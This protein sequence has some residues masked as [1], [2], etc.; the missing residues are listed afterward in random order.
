M[1]TRLVSHFAR[2]LVLAMGLL[3]AIGLGGNFSSMA[4]R[5]SFDRYSLE[6][7]LPQ[8]QV[9]DV[10]QGDRGYLW[11]A[12]LGGGLT[13]FDGYSFK[14]FTAE[15]GLPS[16][17]A[18][19][20]H[21]DSSGTL[22]VGTRNGLARY[23]GGTI[24]SFT[25]TDGLADDHVQ[26]LAEGPHGTLW[27][28][29]PSGVFS[30]REGTFRALAPDQ[31]PDVPYR[32]LA[33]QG[34]T[35]WIGGR[36]G[37]HRYDDTGLTSFVDT[38]RGPTT[39]ARSLVPRTE[40]GLWV[41]TRNG[42]FRFADAEFRRV[43][44]TRSLTVLDVLDPPGGPLWLAT[45][46]GLYRRPADDQPPRRFSEQLKNV[47]V[48][49]LLRDS[50]HSL[51][52]ATDGEGLLQHSPTPFDH[53]TTTDGLAHNLVWDVTAGP[54]EDL[55]I[56]TRDGISRYD[57]TTFTEVT[58]P[59]G[60]LDREL[61]SLHYDHTGTLWIATRTG[62]FSYD[63][64]TYTEHSQVGGGRVGLTVDIAETPSGTLWFATLQN[65]LIRYDGSSFTRYTTED[66][67]SSNHVRALS[68]GP[69]GRL[70]VG[71]QEGLQRFD[72]DTFT[73]LHAVDASQV[74]SL[75][76]L[77]VDPDGYAWLGTQRGVHLYRPGADSLVPFT[78]NDGLSGSTTV[79]LLL[80][81]Q[82]HLWAGTEK[83]VNR[84]DIRGYKRT[85]TMALRSYGPEDGFLGT[86][87]SQHA[88]YAAD[89]GTLW[90]GTGDG[91]TR[92][93]P[94]A[95]R[96]D[97]TPPQVYVTGLRFF[98]QSPADWAQ[99]SDQQAPWSRL[100]VGLRLPHDKNH[101]IF[102]FTG[103]N[104]RAP[105]EVNYQYKLE[106]FDTQWS[107]VQTQRRATYSNIPPGS[108]TFKVKARDGSGPW[109][110]EAATFS[111]SIEPP[112]WQT[113]WFYV[114]CVL[115]AIGLVVGVIRWRTWS[116]EQRQRLLEDK[117]AERTK[118]LEAARE[119]AL[120]AAEAKSEFLANMSHEIR[121]PMNG[122]IG[123][124][125][126]LE[127]TPLSPEQQEFVDAIQRSGDTLL[128]IIDDILD[129]SKLEAG[130]TDLETQ[131]VRLRS[132]VEE[133][134]DPLAT[135]TAEKGV[136]LTYRIDPD[137]PSVIRTDKTRLHQV[138]LNLLSN[139]VKFTEEGTVALH[140]DVVSAPA[141]PNQPYELHFQVRDTGP[142]IPEEQQDGLF[143]SFR[144]A[145]S[146]TT[147]TH[148]GTGLGLSIA[149]QIV[150]AMEGE[151]WVE[152]EV[153]EGSTFHFTIRAAAEDLEE[154][155]DVPSGL[156]GRRVL[157]AAANPTTRALL[158]Q[159][160]EQGGME[161]LPAATDSALLDRLR[162][163]PAFDLI[164]LDARLADADGPAL[165]THL[166]K[167]DAA[168]APIVLLS[169]VQ[170][171]SK[172]GDAAYDAQVHKPI[173]QS[174]L[175]AAM[176]KALGPS[177]ASPQIADGAPARPDR[178]VLRVLLAEDDTVNQQMT[179][180]LLNERG[181]EVQVATTG[182][183]AVEAFREQSPDVIL[184]DVQMPE[185]DGL[186][187]TRRIRDEWPSDEQPYIIA[188]TAAVTEADR[189]R[190]QE[191]GADD[192]LSKPLKSEALADALPDQFGAA[193]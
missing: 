19:A 85:G 98:S 123:F 116:L 52:L 102:R 28:G 51:W 80:D 74:G 177:P 64:G 88:V 9:R 127:D 151:I 38:T 189:R 164:L 5:H 165:A 143:D 99:Y 26:A 44:D 141:E 168:P 156:D 25:Q 2:G 149:K 136:E 34:D 67:L 169:S 39:P 61:P 49:G 65:G 101:L 32:S 82:G 150:E 186:E 62:L 40:G 16:N 147:R 106:G 142:G 138:L 4:Q 31:I 83:G 114:L 87:A 140:V 193:A 132:S 95:D 35:L 60:A 50:D 119:D 171:D 59:N 33:T 134:L 72:G 86:E 182:S 54:D 89:N 77:T 79:S 90:F 173:K 146:S 161:A 180:Q 43:G 63:D 41:G 175:Y 37:V 66:G 187:A 183:E 167:Q 170:Q 160:V 125:D 29:T 14:S 100:P 70:W 73:A 130:Q 24:T 157:V 135:A 71:L 131:P 7:G 18:T 120:A 145:D 104:Y 181:H 133:A 96:P 105:T 188:L 118:E 46:D 121:T 117:V 22:W 1:R 13:R 124:A 158:R 122:V 190:C 53:F 11:L 185:M 17:V 191:A 10:L 47:V 112:F 27:I 97:P 192:F 84:L 111:F 174:H 56:A 30:F 69:E 159:L 110:P 109:T 113:G 93:D 36:G 154:T 8:S 155:Q 23:N 3:W 94:A 15:D 162:A 57:G 75:L 45:Q 179:T 21:Q 128:S 107:P 42:L 137:V 184:M 148:G 153:G 172:A 55:W 152:S 76:S 48:R 108:Y 144:Q 103:L 139:A 115:S 176:A 91:L 126:L 163:G 12:V 6:E 81:Q 178:D 58:G 92:Y 129:F 20:L 68:V 166:H 78:P